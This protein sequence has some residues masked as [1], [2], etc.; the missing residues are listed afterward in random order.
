MEQNFAQE[1]PLTEGE[2]RLLRLLLQRASLPE[3]DFGLLPQGRGS[4]DFCP[5]P[6]HVGRR[7]LLSPQD[8]EAAGVPLPEQPGR[9][10]GNF[11]NFVFFLVVGLFALWLLATFLVLVTPELANFAGW[12]RH[13]FRRLLRGLIRVATF[14]RR[15]R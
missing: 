5:E 9:N 3:F 15:G 13:L 1:P 14:G 6:I 2:V 10:F 4:Q 7:P 12:L 11:G 8:F